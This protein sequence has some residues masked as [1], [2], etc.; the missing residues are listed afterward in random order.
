M[1]ISYDDINNNTHNDKLLD[2]TH[3]DQNDGQ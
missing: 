3:T 2:I 1:K